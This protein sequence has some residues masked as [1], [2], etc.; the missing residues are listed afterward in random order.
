MEFVM[1]VAVNVQQLNRKEGRAKW[2]YVIV[3]FLYKK[4]SLSFS[5]FLYFSFYY[6]PRLVINT[7]QI[8]LHKIKTRTK[9]VT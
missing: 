3:R 8:Y 1:F 7:I 6:L 9:H 4:K 2:K 5:S